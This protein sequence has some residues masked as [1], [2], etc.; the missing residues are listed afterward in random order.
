MRSRSSP[1]IALA[2]VLCTVACSR[3]D[4]DVRR[5]AG[6]LLTQLAERPR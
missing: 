5:R 4:V 1:R 3:A 6:D 2:L